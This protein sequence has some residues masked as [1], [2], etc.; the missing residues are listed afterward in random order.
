M[1]IAPEHEMVDKWRTVITNFD[2]VE[3][4]RAAAARGLWLEPLPAYAR[5]LPRLL[6]LS[7]R[8][9]EGPPLPQLAH[10]LPPQDQRVP[11]GVCPLLPR[12]HAARWG[13]CQGLSTLPRPH[14]GQ[15]QGP[16][17][18]HHQITPFCRDRQRKICR[19]KQRR[20]ELAIMCK[21]GV[22]CMQAACSLSIYRSPTW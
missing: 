12:G 7:L 8:Q 5:P 13:Q 22:A 9:P 2:E 19:G 10:H 11:Q 15:G 18:P 21:G 6:P 14:G 16:V 17:H 3:Q 1:V 20:D 4:Y